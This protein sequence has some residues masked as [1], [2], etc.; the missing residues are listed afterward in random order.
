MD[1]TDPTPS[2]DIT[3]EETLEDEDVDLTP[4]TTERIEPKV[5]QYEAIISLH[6]LS[7]ISSP[8]T[9][10]IQGY[11][12]HHKVVVLID[13]SST[14]NLFKEQLIEKSIDLLDQCPTFKLSSPIAE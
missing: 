4:A 12:K 11:I 3:P 6:A 10:K 8:H 5:H 14:H 7:S 9:L 2:D 1:F 13:T